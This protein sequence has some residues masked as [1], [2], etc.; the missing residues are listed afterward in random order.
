MMGQQI[1]DPLHV[2][3]DVEMLPGLGLLPTV[4]EMGRE[5]VTRQVKFSLCGRSGVMKGYEIHMGTTREAS[6]SAEARPLNR[7]EDGTQEGFIVSPTCMGTYIHGIL[8][9]KEFIDFLLE[10]H[11]QKTK[12]VEAFDYHKF[13]EQQ[14]DRLAEHV[15]KHLNIPLIYDI[16]TGDYD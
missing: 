14:Y 6:G 8:D 9:N 12:E 15:R 2:E 13:K 4:T 1:L 5:K 16:L 7:L 3:G 11:L 10:P